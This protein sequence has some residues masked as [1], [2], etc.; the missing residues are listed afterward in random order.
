MNKRNTQTIFVLGLLLISLFCVTTTSA[1][2][3]TTNAEKLGFP[4]GK[5]VLLLHCDDAGMCEEA[6][7]AVQAYVLKGDITSAAVM[8]PCPDAEEMVEWAKTH[9]QADIGVHLTLTSEWKTYRW[10]PLT[11]A[12]KVPGL[13]DPQGKMWPE[14]RDVVTHA[15]PNEVEIEIRAQID[16]M[17]ELGHRPSHIDTHMGTLY[18]SAEYVRV[19]MKIAEE[20]GIPANAIDLSDPEVVAYYKKAG[21]PITDDVIDILKEY[22]LPK[23]DNF[24][25]VPS[26]KTYEEKRDNFFKLVQSLKPGLTEIIFHPSIVTDNMKTI[27]NS[28]QQRGWEAEMFSDPVVKQF[29]ADNNIELTNWTGIMKRF[30]QQK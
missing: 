23:L 18:G 14:V 3:K 24:S 13:I 17:I 4:K 25:S 29:F 1:Q 30:K 8:M 9:P 5:K 27:T 12:E 21:Y 10:G 26:G 20:Y 28:W 16:K 7:I 22:R 2:E 15:S 19:F 11:Q 6:N